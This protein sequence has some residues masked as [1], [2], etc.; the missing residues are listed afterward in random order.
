M[1]RRCVSALARRRRPDRTVSIV[2]RRMGFLNRS[3]GWWCFFF[4][5]ASPFKLL[6]H[7]YRVFPAARSVL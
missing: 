1:M 4:I 7:N 5:V 3:C 2:F 6:T